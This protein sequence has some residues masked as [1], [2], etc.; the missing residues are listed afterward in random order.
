MLEVVRNKLLC[1]RRKPAGHLLERRAEAPDGRAKRRKP[2]P[3]HGPGG[4]KEQWEKSGMPI[5]EW[6]FAFYARPGY[7]DIEARELLMQKSWA[8]MDDSERRTADKKVML[9][10]R[11]TK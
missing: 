6:D 7:D 9:Q 1:M 3:W 5:W 8:D 11:K 4:G 2:I 10:R